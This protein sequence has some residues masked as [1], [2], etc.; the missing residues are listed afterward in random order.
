M[1]RRPALT[2]TLLLIAAVSTVSAQNPR[3]G[4]ADLR[5]APPM[6]EKLSYVSIDSLDIAIG[7]LPTGDMS[8]SGYTNTR[9][10]VAFTPAGDSV[11]VRTEVTELTGQ[12]QTPM[13]TMPVDSKPPRPTEYMLGRKG[14]NMKQDFN[15]MGEMSMQDLLGM[16]R[17]GAAPLLLL[18]GRELE[19]GQAWTDTIRSSG[20]METLELQVQMIIRGTYVRDTVVDGRTL[21]VLDFQ[22]TMTMKSSGTYQGTAVDQNMDVASDER[23]LWDS[24]R[25]FVVTRSALAKMTMDTSLPGVGSM[26]MT[27]TARSLNRIAN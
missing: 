1:I 24:A 3:R 5:Y 16:A 25:H 13:G 11:R 2:A 9:I 17:S 7:G 20:T 27:G 26:R 21:N 10:D 19:R 14:M 12:M 15:A 6:P 23:V 8:T 18:P 22:N 4:R